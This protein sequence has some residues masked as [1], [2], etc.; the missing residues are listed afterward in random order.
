[1]SLFVWT[2]MQ[3]QAGQSIELTVARKEA[4]RMAGDGV[5]WWGIGNNL[6]SLVAEARRFDGDMPVLFSLMLTKPAKHD[7]NPE[8][9]LLWTA[10]TDADG[11]LHEIPTHIVCLSRASSKPKRYALV[12]RSNCPISVGDHGYFNPPRCTTLLGKSP[13]FNGV[14]AL[15]RGELDE[16]HHPGP[17][18]K[19]FRARLEHPWLVRLAEPR[20]LTARERDALA[21]P[22]S[23]EKWP[24]FT[25][26]LR[27]GHLQ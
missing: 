10:W 24:K 26:D 3:G 27:A 20:H 17:Y 2:R 8:G 16:D 12:C 4:E 21:D 6:L 25:A 19:G 7:V 14:T 11:R 22:L 9:V 13:A 18:R 15:L 5:F 1:M 23:I